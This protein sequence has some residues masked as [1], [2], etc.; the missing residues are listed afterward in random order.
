MRNAAA[1]ACT[2][3][4]NE[5]K[6]QNHTIVDPVAG[7]GL[8]MV[9][10]QDGNRSAYKQLLCEIDNWLSEKEGGYGFELDRAA[11]SSVLIAIHQKRHT[12]TP[13][14]PFSQW[15]CAIVEYKQGL[16]NLPRQ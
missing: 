4:F 5:L 9:A 15:L 10:A 6:E 7:W 8:L 14:R 12:Y 2:A 13:T 3:D 11:K 16:S 1:P